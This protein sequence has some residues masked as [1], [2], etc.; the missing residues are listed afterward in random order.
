MKMILPIEHR[1]PSGKMPATKEIDF[2]RKDQLERKRRENEARQPI[3][4]VTPIGQ[5]CLEHGISR[6]PAHCLWRKSG[7]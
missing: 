3:S 1:S 2:E 7:A 6:N 4:M 5:L